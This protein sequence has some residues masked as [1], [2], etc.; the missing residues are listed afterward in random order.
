[1]AHAE[2]EPI[3]LYYLPA[4]TSAAFPEF[5]SSASDLPRHHDINSLSKSMSH[6]VQDSCGGG[7]CWGGGARNKQYRTNPGGTTGA[8]GIAQTKHGADSEDEEMT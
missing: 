5:H 2:A 3:S 1:M 6:G 8:S 7:G 4:A